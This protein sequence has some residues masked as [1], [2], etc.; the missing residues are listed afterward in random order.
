MQYSKTSFGI[1]DS[2]TLDPKDPNVFQLGQRLGFTERDQYQAMALY[3]CN[4]KCDLRCDLADTMVY[5]S[6]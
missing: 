2:I 4:G 1:N 5:T 6:R 3:Q